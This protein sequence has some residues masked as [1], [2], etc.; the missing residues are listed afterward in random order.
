[1]FSDAVGARMQSFFCQSEFR[2]AAVYYATLGSLHAN[3]FHHRVQ[4]FVSV[5]PDGSVFPILLNLK[6][7]PWEASAEVVD[8]EGARKQVGEKQC[9]LIEYYNLKIA[10][11]PWKMQ[12]KRKKCC[13]YIVDCFYLSLERRQGLRERP[14]EVCAYFFPFD[15]C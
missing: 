6:S 5:L 13:G 12:L 15:F 2:V 7:K 9:D 4:S 1:M 14:K 8:S 11:W 10:L 3:R